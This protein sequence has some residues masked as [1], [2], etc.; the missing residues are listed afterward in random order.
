MRTGEGSQSTGMGTRK[1]RLNPEYAR[2]YE[3]L[4]AGAWLPVSEAA[5]QLVKRAG[6]LRAAGAHRRTFDLRHFEFR[7]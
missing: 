6:R 2:S 3:E 7:G 1:I 4:P 5:E